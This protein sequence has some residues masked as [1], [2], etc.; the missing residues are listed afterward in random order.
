MCDLGIWQV[1]QC[2]SRS[3]YPINEVSVAGSSKEA[4]CAQ[5]LVPTADLV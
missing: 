1:P 2:V 5:E 4:A 3:K